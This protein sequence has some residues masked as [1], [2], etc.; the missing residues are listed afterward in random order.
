MP[1]T[2]HFINIIIIIQN[3]KQGIT[4][5]EVLTN[6]GNII[7]GVGILGTSVEQIIYVDEPI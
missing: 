7:G 4:E 5:E 1:L 3:I 6:K 2:P